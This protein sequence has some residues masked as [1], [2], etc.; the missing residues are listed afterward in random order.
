MSMFVRRF[1]QDPGNTVL[2]NIESVDVIDLTPPS[3]IL[4]IGTGTTMCVGEFED[5]PP[6][7]GKAGGDAGAC[8][9]HQR[10]GS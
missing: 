6:A 4:G 2:L 3:A 9:R 5:A 10:S 8:E 7:G 1:T